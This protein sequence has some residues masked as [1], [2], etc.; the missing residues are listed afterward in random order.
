MVRFHLFPQRFAMGWASLSRFVP[1]LGAPVVFDPDR[2]SSLVETSRI[3]SRNQWNRTDLAAAIG[4]DPHE[5]DSTGRVWPP[6]R[7]AVRQW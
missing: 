2:P 5:G 3:A 1:P 4:H 7:V 6:S